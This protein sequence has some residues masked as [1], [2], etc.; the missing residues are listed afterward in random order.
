VLAVG[1][2]CALGQGPLVLSFSYTCF[3]SIEISLG[4]L[5]FT[6]E[7]LLLPELGVKQTSDLPWAVGSWNG[8]TDCV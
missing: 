6:C 3:G 7:C 4:W 1:G 8:F 5:C 2:S